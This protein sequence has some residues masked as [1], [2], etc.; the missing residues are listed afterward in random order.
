MHG[1]KPGEVVH[2]DY[3]HDGAS[4][5]LGGDCLDEDEGYRYVLVMMTD[6][7]YWFWLEP[8][9]ARSARLTAQPLLAWY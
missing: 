1:T 9:E 2:F 6:M 8:T 4:G 3:F 7:S 5:P